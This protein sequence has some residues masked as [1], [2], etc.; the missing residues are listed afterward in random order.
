LKEG[1]PVRGTEAILE[2]PD[3]TRVP[4]MPYPTPLRDD[5]GQLIG[6]VNLLLDLTE[7]QRAE[8]ESE[9]LAAI[10]ATSQDAIISKTIDGRI[11]SWNEGATRIFGWEAGEMIGQ[12]ITRII[13]PELHHEEEQILAKL[14]RGERIEHYETVRISKHGRRLDISLAV[15]PLHDK[16]GRVIGASKVAR[17]EHACDCAGYR[18]AV[19]A[20][21]AQLG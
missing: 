5:S 15:S 8:G 13:P 2:R 11:T 10:V 19:I 1:R 12:S 3:G 9:R 6:A 14:R 7:R 18:Q 4:F 21:G 17:Q 20:A 16:W